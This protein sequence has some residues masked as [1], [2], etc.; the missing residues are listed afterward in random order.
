M[1]EI[2]MIKALPSQLKKKPAPGSELG[3]GRFLTDYMFLMDY[4]K[5][6]GW[7]NPRIEPYH[8]LPLDPAALVLH[9]G[10]EVFEGLKAYRWPNDEICLF[11]PRMNY[12]RMNRSVRRLCMPELDIE[13]A[14]EATRQLIRLEKDWV[15]SAPGTS[16]YVRP[17]MIA[18]EA[19]LG[20]QLSKKY[21]FYIILG[22]V[23]A[24]YPQGFNPTDI[25]VCEKYVRAARGG[26]GEAKTMANYAASLLAAEEAHELGYTQVLWLDAIERKYAE[27]VGTSNIFFYI[28]DELI[29]PSLDGTI[30]PGVTR[31]SVLHIARNWEMKVSERKIS[32]EEVISALESGSLKEI[33]ASGTAAVISP[34]GKLA[35][36]EKTYLVNGGKVGPL[37]QKLYNTIM[38]I[39]YG[40]I[41]DPYG[42]TE[43]V[44]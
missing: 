38:G 31:N 39:Q 20:V 15:P 1:A 8:A 28:G 40:K 22:P 35:Y 23:G 14:L 2:P 41:K 9:Y 11:R 24:Y 25:Y 32:L 26:L 33:F 6:E 42:W 13:F 10:Q 44:A 19:A 17:N 34:V 5:G 3:F 37:A 21:L 43:R 4:E 29:T 7:K 18:V 27:E 16:L 36:R 12:Q 30:L